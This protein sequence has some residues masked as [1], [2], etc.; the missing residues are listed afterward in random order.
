MRGVCRTLIRRSLESSDPAR[1]ISGA[2]KFGAATKS[3]RSGGEIRH[4]RQFSGNRS[5]ALHRRVAG[6][7]HFFQTFLVGLPLLHRPLPD[8]WRWG[9]GGGRTS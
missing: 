6:D 5:A 2:A 9:G 3:V 4:L 7:P 8:R 1:R